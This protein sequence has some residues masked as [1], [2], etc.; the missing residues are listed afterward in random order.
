MPTEHDLLHERIVKLESTLRKLVLAVGILSVVLVGT[1]LLDAT[2]FRDSGEAV[3]VVD[4]VRARGFELVDRDG[5]VRAE[6]RHDAEETGLFVMDET[7]TT[8][9]GAAQF[10]HGGGGF[11]LHGPESR[12]AAVLYLKGDG[13]LTFFDAGGEIRARFPSGEAP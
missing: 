2:G 11:A 9:L 1:I 4:L 13:T 6:L 7:G 5:R 12:G 10:A 3:P 8:R